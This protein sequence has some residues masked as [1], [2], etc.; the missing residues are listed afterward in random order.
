MIC[1]DSAD[2]V[3]LFP[4]QGT[5][6]NW[7]K[8]SIPSHDP[9]EEGFHSLPLSLR[10]RPRTGFRTEEKWGKDK[11]Q[12]MSSGWEKDGGIK[13]ES[14]AGRCTEW[15]TEWVFGVRRLHKKRR[16]TLLNEINAGYKLKD[17]RSFIFLDLN[18]RNNNNTGTLTHDNKQT[19]NIYNYTF[20]EF[21]TE[22]LQVYYNI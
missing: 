21:T 3:K 11:T 17:N 22:I 18:V 19:N 16:R 1:I 12:P 5:V 13:G 6:C 4:I 7:R 15:D 9:Q 8:T 14:R 20:R 2:P 10:D